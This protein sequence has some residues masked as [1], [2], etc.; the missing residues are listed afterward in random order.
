MHSLAGLAYDE[1][2]AGEVVCLVHAGVFGAWFAPLFEQPALD[3]FRVIRPIR[4]GYGH[5]PGAIRAG[6][7]RRPRPPLRRA[8]AR[9]RR[10]PRPLGR[11]LQQLLHRAAARPRRP[12]P[13]RQPDPLR[14]GQ[15]LRQAAGGGRIDLCR[16]RAGGRGQRRHRPRVRRV[17]ARRGRRRLPGGPADPV[18]GRRPGRGRTRVGLLLH[19]RAAGTGRLDLRAGRGGPG[20]GRHRPCCSAAPN[21]APGSAKTPPSWPTYSPTRAPKPCPRWIT[22]PPS[23]TPRSSP[24]PSG[25]SSATQQPRPLDLSSPQML[26]ALQG[27]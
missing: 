13:G 18:R 2:G 20:R 26:P 19:R 11:A 14:T 12:R 23:P 25:N 15:A 1:R 5:S 3:G 6:Q 27:T 9:T 17:P 8:A 10:H 24:R 22:S 21:P 7:H 16:P 4:P